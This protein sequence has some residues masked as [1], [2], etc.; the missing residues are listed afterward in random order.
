[1]DQEQA[2]QLSVARDVLDV[3]KR[4]AHR[5]S[6]ERSGG[7]YTLTICNGTTLAMCSLLG[8][9][10]PLTSDEEIAMNKKVFDFIRTQVLDTFPP[11]H[12]SIN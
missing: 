9:T 4:H 6:D 11:M 5:L 2:E 8:R 7:D 12:G 3:M 1:M 10:I